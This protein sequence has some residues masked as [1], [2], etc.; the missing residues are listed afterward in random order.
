[1]QKQNARRK[2]E[3]LRKSERAVALDVLGEVLEGGA[4]AN[5]ALRKAF[6]G[7]ESVELQARSRAFIT[8]VVNET[9]RNLILI[10][11]I[12]SKFSKTPSDKL[13]PFI[14]NLLRISVCQMRFMD[15]VPDHAAINEAV[16]LAK[17]HG[18]I[19]LSGFVNGVLR[20]M[21]RKPDFPPMPS[22]EGGRKDDTALR[23]S[24]PR[25]LFRD[26]VRWLGKEGAR[27]FCK[28]SHNPPPVTVYVNT[29]KINPDGLVEM[30]V[31]ERN[32]NPPDSR[33]PLQIEK[34][35]D[36][37]PNI[38]SLK[39]TG[40]I[41]AIESFKNGLFFV[42]D[43]GAI[44]AVDALDPKPG[45]CII[46]LTAAPGGKAF[47]S[48]CKMENRG[49]ILAFDIHPHRVDL[50]KTTQKRLGIN[51][52]EPMEGDALIL[53][54]ELE[55]IADGVLLDA[56]CSG[57]GTIRKHPEIKYFRTAEDITTLAEKQYQMLGVAA[58]YVKP[59]GTLVYCTCTVA[60]E[61]NVMNVNLFLENHPEYI[62][63]ETSQILPGA[64]SD[65]FFTAK[66][67]RLQAKFY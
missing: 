5:I 22:A 34:T 26:L 38:L 50:I 8:E 52:I 11:Y 45:Q 14:R 31:K 53:N 49:K 39:G 25:P 4:F 63:C 60:D 66:F 43:S 51:I 62:L 15:K 41:S 10:D 17:L 16:E 40:D 46:D 3:N 13:K 55:G 35:P 1:M 61:E 37:S 21:A 29:L 6:Q 44:R 64:H 33:P 57:L 24:Y 32:E 59:G 47:V 19:G 27:A 54:P 9:L 56:P 23:Y 2:N 67:A 36:S 28:A 30:L 42:M 18:F 12:I 48:A 58:R 20:N 7:N 65:G